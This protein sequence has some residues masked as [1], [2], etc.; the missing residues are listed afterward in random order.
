[1]SAFNNAIANWSV[2]IKLI[3]EIVY[4]YKRKI[5]LLYVSVIKT[6]VK[7]RVVA[8][9]AERESECVWQRPCYLYY[10]SLHR[11][12]RI[13]INTSQ[14][15]EFTAEQPETAAAADTMLSPQTRRMFTLLLFITLSVDIHQ[16]IR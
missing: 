11:R 7:L 3:N 8:K 6:D 15:E 2:L 5:N 16:A 12:D 4:Q 14:V 10:I 9:Q 1:M 13:N